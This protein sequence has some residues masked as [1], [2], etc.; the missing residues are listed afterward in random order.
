M[1]RCWCGAGYE[2]ESDCPRCSVRF[3]QLEDIIAEHALPTAD[4]PPDGPDDMLCHIAELEAQVGRERR[5]L[6]ETGGART[7]RYCRG[8]IP[9]GDTAG[10]HDECLP[11]VLPEGARSC[12]GC[13]ELIL[14]DDD[15]YEHEFCPT[16][17]DETETEPNFVSELLN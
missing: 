10:A 1:S 8:L 12:A 6:E 7:C 2:D 13:A 11:A 3:V 17:A 5:V 9:P 16:P 15:E 14:D 4:S